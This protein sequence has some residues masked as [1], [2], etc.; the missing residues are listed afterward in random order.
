MTKDFW[1]QAEPERLA[2]STKDVAERPEKFVVQSGPS[3]V[4][5]PAVVARKTRF[6]QQS[7]LSSP[8]NDYDVQTPGR[9]GRVEFGQSRSQL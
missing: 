7:N 9:T 5:P 2:A 8:V 3:V 1:E 6:T 4:R